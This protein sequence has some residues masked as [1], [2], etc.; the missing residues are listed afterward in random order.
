MLLSG[1]SFQ[2]GGPLLA[3]APPGDCRD[4][5]ALRAAPFLIRNLGGYIAMS[6]FFALGRSALGGLIAVSV[7][8][9]LALAQDQRV[10]VSGG[11]STFAAPAY[12]AWIE[13]YGAV[14]PTVA[15]GYDVIGSGEG[16]GR[17]L[18]GTL[19]FAATDAPLT[20]EQESGVPGGVTHIPVTAGMIAIAYNLPAGL[21]GELRLPSDVLGDIF[22]GT[23]TNWDDPRLIA[24][25][26]DL[27]L[28]HQTIQ[29]VARQDG[30]GTTYA[31]TNHLEAISESW[32]KSGRGVRTLVGWPNNAMRA[33]GNE[34]VAAMIL[35]SE[36]SIG[37][38]EFSIARAAGL[39]LAALEN[40]SGAY[41]VPSARSGAA[42]IEAAELPDDMKI[43]IP[44]PVGAEAYPI[45][46]FTWELLRNQPQDRTED[47]AVRAFTRWAIADGQAL[48]T[49][50]GYV[51]MPQ[52]VRDRADAAVSA[53]F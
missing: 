15:I 27:A 40:A 51:P 7:A 31:F 23:I 53:G 49:D 35:R 44:N 29:V 46:T 42:A 52:A 14:A 36:G 3:S 12:K 4:E 18:A 11:G 17:F 25:N 20:A 38:V 24:A 21:D 2:L 13:A 37:Y 19:D 39:P 22:A 5:L 26:P 45:V 33:R 30:S 48:A 16:I 41:V 9:P 10:S 50:L 43:D 6:R 34:G 28:P 8:V 47:E 32:R 1:A